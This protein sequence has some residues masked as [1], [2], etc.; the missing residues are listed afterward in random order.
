MN[1]KIRPLILFR[2]LMWISLGFATTFFAFTIVAATAQ[3]VFKD[4]QLVMVVLFLVLTLGFSISAV[5]SQMMIRN[6]KRFLN[7][8]MIENSYT[9]GEPTQ[10]YNL[11]AFKLRV[12]RLSRRLKYKKKQQYVLAFTPTA[13]D[14]S[15]NRGRDKILTSINLKLAKFLDNLFEVNKENRLDERNIVYAFSRGTFFFCLFSDD[16]AFV[17]EL[18]NAVS[19]ECFRMVNEDK[20]KIWMQPF[21]GIKK[22]EQDESIVSA[23]EDA[24]IAR[25]HAEKNYESYAY[26]I[27][28]FRKGDTSSEVILNALNNNE[29]VP[30]YQ[31]KYSLKEKKYIS[32]EA[33]AR[34]NSPEHGLVGPGKFIELAERAGLLSSIDTR[35]FELA[36][37]DVSDAMKRGR[38]VVPVSV[39]F[40][41]YE[42][43]SRNFLDT[44]VDTLKKYDVPPHLLEIEI[45]ET[46]SQVNKFLSLSVIKKLKS[47]G[48]R[49]LMDDFG[50]GYSQIENMREIPFDAI[51]ID[52]SFTDKVLTDTKTASI[53]KYLVQLAHTNG[54]EAIIEGAETKEQVEY[55]KKLNVDTIQGFYYSKP[56]PA[57]EFSELLRNSQNVKRGGRRK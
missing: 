30:F 54:M 51:K 36:I 13:V 32:C 55:L 35:I 2:L 6:Q 43:F 47:I 3:S 19:N 37:K 42:F 31:V 7:Q 23:I 29:F 50:V 45:T 26:F 56:L 52:K 49:V 4:K 33:L 34:W 14:I 12:D 44:I 40:S 15:S 25:D 48:I 57:D 9:L 20:V 28:S 22:L 16:D 38:P 39:N 27:D 41:L 1:T 53:V 11:D 10:F 21:F 17:T 18:I 5:L 46:T 24:L 8:L